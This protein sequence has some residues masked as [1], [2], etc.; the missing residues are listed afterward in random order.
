MAKTDHVV[1]KT[2]N[3][4]KVCCQMTSAQNC[5]RISSQNIK[6]EK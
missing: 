2:R 6:Q 5:G 3:K 4:E 1:P